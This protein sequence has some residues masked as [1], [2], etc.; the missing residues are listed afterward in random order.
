MLENDE[1]FP[2]KVQFSWNDAMNKQ[3][4]LVFRLTLSFSHHFTEAVRLVRPEFRW[5]LEHIQRERLLR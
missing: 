4:I 1:L 5:M 2:L 3:P